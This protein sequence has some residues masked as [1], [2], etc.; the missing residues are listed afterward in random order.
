MNIFGDEVSFFKQTEKR[1]LRQKR[2]YILEPMGEN[3]VLSRS[4]LFEPILPTDPTSRWLKYYDIDVR[5]IYVQV[6]RR[7]FNLISSSR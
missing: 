6:L 1:L 5:R 4:P 3:P 7:N 2:L